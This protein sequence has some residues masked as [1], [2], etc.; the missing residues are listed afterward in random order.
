MVSSQHCS[1]EY[2]RY[3]TE[4]MLCAGPLEGG[5]GMC[6][7]DSGGPLVCK[8]GDRWL[9]YGVVSWTWGGCAKPNH[10]GVY[11]DVVKFLPWI[12]QKT[13]SQCLRVYCMFV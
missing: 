2:G 1:V 7:G 11:V 10:P 4:N 3:F 12:Q 6:F 5:K 13:G 9:Q 8:Q